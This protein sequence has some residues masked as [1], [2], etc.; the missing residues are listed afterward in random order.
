M[1]VPRDLDAVLDDRRSHRLEGV[2]DLQ[3]PRRIDDALWTNT[4]RLLL[5]HTY[6][7]VCAYTI[8]LVPSI[9]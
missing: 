1:E 6:V 3:R 9:V 7:L 2:D 8:Q 4:W 5:V